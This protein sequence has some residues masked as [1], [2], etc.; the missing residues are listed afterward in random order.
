[1]QENNF[2]K[3]G[4]ILSALGS[5]IG[6]GHIWRFPYVAGESGGGAF[7]L[8]FLVLALTIGVAL[9]I[10]EMLIGNRG[11]GSAVSSYE[12]LDTTR[13]KLWKYAALSS[14]AGPII[15]TFYCV[16][17]GWVLYYMIIISFNLPIDP[18][19]SSKTFGALLGERVF[20]QALCLFIIIAITAYFVIR[21]AKGGIEKLNVVLMPMLFLI[22]LGLLIYAASFDSFGRGLK[23]MFVPDFSKITSDVIINAL[24]QM[25][26]A[27]SIGVCTMISYASDVD[28][29][30]N[31]LSSALWIVIPGIVISLVAGIIIFTFVFEFNGSVG[32][33]PGLV[34]VTLPLIFKQMG[35]I[36][37][38]ICFLFMAGLLFAGL[39]STVSIL[40]PATKI[41]EERANLS[42][43][44][45]VFLLS[46][47]IFVV[48]IL[49]I[50]SLN[51]NLK[52]FFTF[53]GKS[54]F[55]ILDNFS[56]N[57]LIT[58][59]GLA[60]CIFAGWIIKKD[61]LRD[62]TK[63]F[64]TAGLF[65]IWLFLMRFVAPVIIIAIM[66]YKIKTS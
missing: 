53:G 47:A 59:G 4:F 19:Q 33:G 39:T 40:E 25:F 27:L 44:A 12:N 54:L 50:L 48:G 66:L 45:A 16:V 52:E 31:F 11:G 8:L 41:L 15:L 26:F 24:G 30:Q 9:L 65:T 36:G 2:S 5:A 17:L 32:A 37:W 51:T 58:L 60:G 55:D 21:G 10:G 14:I 46:A 18:E 56:S 64:L 23:F 7:V 22:F 43:P 6:L 35:T 62:F 28:K 1:M 49:V 29:K 63:N 57:Y 38:L 20:L 13:P 42:R 61:T 3:I 34:F